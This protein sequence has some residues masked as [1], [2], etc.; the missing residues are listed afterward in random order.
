MKTK[1]IFLFFLLTLIGACTEYREERAL[2][3]RI[4]ELVE[5][6]KNSDCDAF[7]S[8]INPFYELKTFK[9]NKEA[10]TQHCVEFLA[11]NKAEMEMILKAALTSR[12][13]FNKEMTMATFDLSYLGLSGG[14]SKI[15]FVKVNNLWY[16]TP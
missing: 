1:S 14:K 11:E 2:K 4:E 7:S 10:S 15:S 3:G 8:Y 16:G 5:V 6:I 13:A 12:C 9:G